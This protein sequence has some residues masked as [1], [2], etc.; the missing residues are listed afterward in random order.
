M[1]HKFQRVVLHFGADKT[2]S[3]AIQS[4]LDGSRCEL[5]ESAQV[6]YPPGVWHAQLG[7]V[8]SAF[9]EQYIFNQMRG[10][11]DADY[12]READGQYVEEL[13]QWI[14]AAPKCESLVFSYEG[15]VCLDENALWKFK[16][17]C[18]HLAK[19]VTVV[20]YVR[21]PLSYAVS[22]MSQRVKQGQLSWS[23]NDPPVFP[24]QIFLKTITSV[25]G[26]S[27]VCVR[28][29]SP[30]T[31]EKGDVVADFMTILKVPETIVEKMLGSEAR[32]NESLSNP[33]QRIGETFITLLATRG[34]KICDGEFHK[35]YGQHLASIPG[36]AIR[37]NV[38]QVGKLFTASLPHTQY[39]EE[40]FG[41][42]FDE[43]VNKYLRSGNEE[44]SRQE[45]LFF[46]VGKVLAD[47]ALPDLQVRQDF[48]SPDFLL[49]RAEVN[50]SKT[51]APGQILCFDLEFYLSH[52]VEELEVAM[53]VFDESGRK[54]FATNNRQMAKPLR[55][56]TRGV[57]RVSYFLMAN[58]SAGQYSFGFAV[59]EI[60][61]DGVRDLAWYDRIIPFRVKSPLLVSGVGY[62]SLPVEFSYQQIS[63]TDYFGRVGSAT[64]TLS[65]DEV[66]KEVAIEE[67]F[68]L[69]VRL[70]N[71]SAETWLNNKFHPI[72]LSYHWHDLE[73]NPVVVEGIRSILPAEKVL[74]GQII[75]TTMRVQAPGM[76]G[77]Y[78]LVL[79]PVQEGHC[80]FDQRGFSPGVLEITVIEKVKI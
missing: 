10:V 13:N 33:A 77:C 54:A 46:S 59:A 11:I 45:A 68:V 2:G 23:D 60:R 18:A 20:L 9:P 17:Y 73:D 5:L 30:A 43:D 26:K 37:L 78:R 72:N 19:R 50:G 80:W 6:A 34:I 70:E 65:V 63:K 28:V 16:E 38:E 51:V 58:L 49:V 52:D 31:L 1:K 67:L 76:P 35:K 32:Q 48:F 61:S 64:G 21:P 12:L 55:T 3:T 39:L 74:S 40:E 41:V 71:T 36:E 15:F 14:K 8:F 53:Y 56:V 29:F 69:P 47:I 4:A 24:S 22:A 57:H 79:M 27:N 75:A 66:P 7:S 44:S 62:V 42:I 25:F